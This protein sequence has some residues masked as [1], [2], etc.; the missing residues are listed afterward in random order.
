MTK[1]SATAEK[2]ATPAV[3]PDGLAEI[4]DIVGRYPDT[5]RDENEVVVAYL[6]DGPI[7]DRNRLLNMT[8]IHEQ[9]QQFQMDHQ[10]EL[11]LPLRAYVIAIGLVLGVLG[12]IVW[13][14]WDAG[15]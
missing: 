15:L 3:D 13:A 2:F 1:R 8:A 5:R 6:R 7:T 4:V 10:K 11:S 14:L 12:L 9:L